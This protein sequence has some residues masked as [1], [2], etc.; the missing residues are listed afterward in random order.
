MIK[1][2]IADDHP[3]FTMGIKLLLSKHDNIEIVGI[4]YDGEEA[5]RMVNGHK[6]DILLLDIIMPKKNG[7]DVVKELRQQNN[8]TKILMLSSDQNNE[9]IETLVSAGINGFVSKYTHETTI[10]NAIDSVYN[11]YNY[12]GTDI[13]K[14]IQR[15]VTAKNATDQLFTPRELDIIKLS[16]TGMQYKEIATKLGISTRTVDTIKNNIFHKLGINSTVELVLYALR[17]G[18]ISL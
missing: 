3:I 13:S 15:I 9:H 16:G 7:I 4:A 14:L 11:N 6:P 10:L 12:F 2:V 8:D 5:I 1:L 17:K 18:I